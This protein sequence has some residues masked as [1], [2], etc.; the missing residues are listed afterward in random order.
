MLWVIP[1]DRATPLAL[2][3]LIVGGLCV[4]LGSL[5]LPFNSEPRGVAYGQAFTLQAGEMIEV[6]HRLFLRLEN[7]QPDPTCSSNPKCSPFRPAQARV[8]AFSKDGL[9]QIR[10]SAKEIHVLEHTIRWLPADASTDQAR[11]LVQH[12][13]HFEQPILPE[14]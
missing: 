5:I 7:L 11:F 1:D 10:L 4:L 9:E 13:D 8:L 6:N 3:V 12:D 14:N 2:S